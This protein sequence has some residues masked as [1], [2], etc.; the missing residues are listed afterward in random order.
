[1]R[2]VLT[3]E[4]QDGMVLSRD[5]LDSNYNVLLRKGSQLYE[6]F[7]P[8]LLGYG[9]GGVY[10]EDELSEGIEIQEVIPPVLRMEALQCIKNLNFEKCMDISKKI[11]EAIMES[12]PI[13]LD[14]QDVRSYD[15][16]TYV[17]S[18][19]VA[20]IC[21][22][23]GL[24]LRMSEKELVILISAAILHDVGKSSIPIEII[25]K[26][27]KLTK[28]EYNIIKDH[29]RRGY[30]MLK[31]RQDLTSLTRNAILEHHENYDGTGYPM[32]TAGHNQ[33][34][35]TRILHVADVFDALTSVRPYKKAYSML[36]AAEF[37]MANSGT[38]FD[39]G[40]V[41][42]LLKYVPLYPKGKIVTLSNGKNA[43]VLKNTDYNNMR[44]VV[45]YTD[46]FEEIDLTDVKYLNLTIINDNEA[47]L[48]NMLYEQYRRQNYH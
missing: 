28:Q 4:I 25:Q 3:E 21:A 23:I 16:Y 41:S 20:S 44:P 19:N 48:A 27:D 14:M 40:I 15:D 39:P 6:K 26:P 35:Y 29:P 33:T 10:I 13:M 31:D 1:M 37:M 11:V 46:T 22:N 36:E 17:H 43:I 42:V 9:I 18:V 12:G 38:M 47:S 5:I 24:G 34:I 2:L 30:D 8:K 45:R 32:G 7:I